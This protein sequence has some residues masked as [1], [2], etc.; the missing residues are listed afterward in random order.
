MGA[1][2]LGC[3]LPLGMPILGL[4]VRRLLPDPRAVP[5]HGHVRVRPSAGSRR[6]RGGGG[7]GRLG[8]LRRAQ[9]APNV[10]LLAVLGCL[11]Q[12]SRLTGEGGLSERL[13]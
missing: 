1:A 11:F 10:P 13:P 2:K 4:V 12:N 9:L 6:C 7:L 8:I 3:L 5:E